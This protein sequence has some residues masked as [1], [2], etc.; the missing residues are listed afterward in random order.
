M[1]ANVS[2]QHLTDP[3]FDPIWKAID[4]AGL[5]VLVHPGAPP[6][7]SA[8][9]MQEFHLSASLGFTFDTS[10]AVSRMILNGFFERYSKL[11]I[12]AAHAGGALPFLAGRLDVC[13]E[14]IPAARA[15][16]T[17]KPSN[18]L[19]QV[20][21]TRWCSGR[22]RSTWRCRCSAPTTCSTARTIRTTSAT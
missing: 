6:G 9:G 12:I 4:D 18:Y 14:N 2:G 8:L 7:S 11:K 20:Y 22:T 1:I 21:A 19:R 15:K 13:W 5:P 3:L 17:E 10:L 16:T